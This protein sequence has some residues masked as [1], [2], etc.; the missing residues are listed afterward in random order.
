MTYKVNITENTD[1]FEVYNDDI[2]DQRPIDAYQMQEEIKNK[3]RV[4]TKLLLEDIALA[5]ADEQ[6]GAIRYSS[7]SLS[8]NDYRNGFRERT[9]STS[10]G[11]FTVKVPRVRGL[12]LSFSIFE[13]YKRKWRELDQI[14]LDAHIGGLSCR[15]AGERLA[16]LLGCEFSGATI[17]KLKDNLK[18]KLKQFK[19]MPLEDKY[20]AIILDGM[21]V[22]IKQCGHQKRPLIAV[23]ADVPDCARY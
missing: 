22:R 10:M 5:E 9:V 21:F 23:I 3:I 12:S 19:N 4:S 15:D 6:I 13:R 1:L 7:N 18:D 2:F 8:R 11:R 14:L 20:V 17:A 16:K